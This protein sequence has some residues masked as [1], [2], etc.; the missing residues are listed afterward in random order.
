MLSLSSLYKGGTNDVGDTPLHWA[1]L[2]GHSEIAALLIKRGAVGDVKN[3]AGQTPLQVAG[4]EKVG[5]A[6]QGNPPSEIS[7][8]WHL[9]SNLLFFFF[10][11]I[12]CFFLC[13]RADLW[14]KKSNREQMWDVFAAEAAHE[15]KTKKERE[16]DKKG[17]H[18]RHKSLGLLSLCCFRF[19]SQPSPWLLSSLCVQL[20]CLN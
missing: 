7:F 18:V 4:N 13:L 9:S 19:Q 8:R 2:G 12:V 20:R 17:G 3:R 16:E 14:E 5:K 10:F 6:I 11:L 1:S 15:Q